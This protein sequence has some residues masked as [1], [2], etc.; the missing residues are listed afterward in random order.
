MSQSRPAPPVDTAEG[1]PQV[2]ERVQRW[3]TVTDPRVVRRLWP[4]QPAGAQHA[5]CPSCGET[6]PDGMLV[7]LNQLATSLQTGTVQ[8][9]ISAGDVEALTPALPIEPG[10]LWCVVCLPCLE[11]GA[12][13]L[14]GRGLS[15][16]LLTIV[17][18]ALRGD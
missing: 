11:A 17:D 13:T 7:T 1:H 18:A 15:K 8:Q 6:M 16:H 3:A 5:L 14:H 4:V 12:R 2:L 10:E 9:V